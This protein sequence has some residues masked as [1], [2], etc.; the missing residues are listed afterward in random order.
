M[1]ISKRERTIAAATAV[2]AVLLLGDR[3]FLTPALERREVVIAETKECLGKLERANRLFAK[4]RLLKKKWS[5]ASTGSMKADASA[6]ESQLLHALRDWAQDAGLIL[7][8]MKPE[9]TETDKQFQ[10]LAF[11]ATGSGGM[12]AVS[13]FLWRIHTC[14]MPARILDVQVSSRKDGND[15]LS[16]ELR[17]STLCPVQEAAAA[18]LQASAALPK[19]AKE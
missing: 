8:T 4:E 17:I 5:D 2:A 19:E 14:S 7:S 16:I 9:Q 13:G 18:P 3:Y 10:K 6:A 12:R 15:D 11:R 1:A